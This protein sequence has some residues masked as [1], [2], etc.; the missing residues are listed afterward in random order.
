MTHSGSINLTEGTNVVLVKGVSS[1]VSRESIRAQ[2]S[3]GVKVLSLGFETDRV[4]TGTRD[5]MR[6]S[7][8]SD[9][10]TAMEKEKRRLTMVIAS[11]EAEKNTIQSNSN[12]TQGQNNVTVAELTKISELYRVRVAEIY[13]QV[14]LAN[15]SLNDINRLITRYNEESA[16]LRNVVKVEL[17]YQIALTVH[18]PGPVTSNMNLK[19]IVGGAA[20]APQYDIHS[21]GID[22]G[23]KLDYNAN[24]MNQTG[25]DWKDVKI[26]LSTADPYQTHNVP[27]LLPWY[28]NY[29]GGSNNNEEGR[30]MSR[31][32]AQRQYG[33]VKVLDNVTYQEIVLNN[34]SVDFPIT[35]NYSIPSD[36]KPYRLEV[37][38]Y[39]LNATFKYFAIPKMD[40]DAFLVAQLTGWEKLNLIQGPSSIYFRGT[41]IGSSNINPQ[42]SEDTL[43]ISMG[44]D[45]KVVV[46][47]VKLEDK[48]AQKVIGTHKKETYTYKISVRNGNAQTI[49]LELHDQIPV[50]QN[51]EITVEVHEL[52][53]AQTEEY[54]GKLIWNTEIKSGETKEFLISFSV[55]YP[56]GK[57]VKVQKQDKANYKTRSAAKF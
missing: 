53:N 16:R 49:S 4:T 41:Y 23:I 15:E 28:L 48:D 50:S 34:V 52:S 56:K 47:R 2:F 39:D 13:K 7:R 32:E 40:K 8:I 20:W 37:T 26:T 33:D 22:K 18:A 42:T 5:S 9:T 38:T 11:L 24:L 29:G 21:E 17:F 12:L 55:K 30:Q 36:S 57:N 3:N 19:Y 31:E 1:K 45:N 44:R 27:G 6:M 35:G 25:E 10:I 14:F 51:S 46:N 43:N 54:S